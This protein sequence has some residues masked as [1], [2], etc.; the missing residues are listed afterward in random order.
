M[1]LESV[2]DADLLAN[3]DF[4]TLPC[5]GRIESALILRTLERGYAG[6]AVIGCPEENCKY[7]SGNK[8]AK[9]RVDEVKAILA[10][11]GLEDESVLMEYISSVDA[12]KIEKLMR[13]IV[14][15]QKAEVETE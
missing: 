10:A 1:A 8:H 4:V 3:F 2:E 12:H 6:V 7:V 5:S 15:P 13:D 14:E 9:N 11:A